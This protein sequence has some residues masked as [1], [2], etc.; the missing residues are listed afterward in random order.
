MLHC[1]LRRR[2]IRL[3]RRGSLIV[4]FARDSDLIGGSIV[5]IVRA[6]QNLIFR[7]Q[8]AAIAGLS[9]RRIMRQ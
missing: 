9:F 8:L 5:V 1:S 3:L 2:G 7:R 6:S 4:M